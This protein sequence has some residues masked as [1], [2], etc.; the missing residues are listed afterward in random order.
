[1]GSVKPHLLTEVNNN[2]G[3]ITRLKYAPSTKFYLRDERKGTP[4]ITKL[5]FPV[6]VVERIEHW[7]EVN[8]NRLVTHYVY[9][10]GYFD[11][12]ER[13]FR[14][15]GVVEQWDGLCGGRTIPCRIQCH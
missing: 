4:W 14:G 1:M 10:Y 9:H 3:S 12:A 15:F 5:P 11:G 13:E 6:Q 2:M 8:H 7:D